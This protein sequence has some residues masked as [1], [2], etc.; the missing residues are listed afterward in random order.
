MPKSSVLIFL[1]LHAL[2]VSISENLLLLNEFLFILTFSHLFSV[3]KS[4][5]PSKTYIFTLNQRLKTRKHQ[6]TSEKV[7]KKKIES[8]F[9]FVTF[10]LFFAIFFLNFY[11][12][13]C[14]G[15]NNKKIKIDEIGINGPKL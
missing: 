7:E 14:K 11:I 8:S 1:I 4:N 9:T 3:I 12:S 13:S 10:K 2:Y 5:K 6:K 15:R